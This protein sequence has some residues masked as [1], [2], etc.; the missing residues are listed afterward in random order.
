M[1]KQW[2][3]LL[4]IRTNRGVKP[5][6]LGTAA[7]ARGWRVGTGTGAD[8]GAFHADTVAESFHDCAAIHG[9]TAAY[10]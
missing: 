10:V 7:G 1:K 6:R 4:T 5:V 8:F 9:G 2:G 3:G